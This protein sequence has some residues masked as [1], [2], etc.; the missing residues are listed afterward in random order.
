MVRRKVPSELD[1][2]EIKLS[3]LMN[4]RDSFNEQ[5]NVLRQ[6][7]DQLHEQ[8]RSV[9]AEVRS[10]KGAR[11][12]FVREMRAHKGVRNELQ[13]KAK[14]LVDIRRE[15][16]GKMKENVTGELASLRKD[17]KRIEMEQQTVPMKLD[18][19]N[20]LIENLRATMRHIRE[21]E[22]MKGQQDAV[23]KE[24]R[25]LDSTIDDLFK[26]ADTEHE[27]VVHLSR[28]ANDL[29]DKVTEL[30]KNIAILIVE[31]DKKHEEYLETRE[32]A[33]EIHQ[34]VVEMREKVLT[35]R[36]AQ[37]AEVREVRQYLK[38]HRLEVRRNLYDEK[39]LDEFADKA[40]QALLNKGKVEIRG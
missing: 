9:S 7:R 18:E 24:V 16:R 34:K 22:K 28:K 32:K 8:K 1:K 23:T 15:F 20:E 10:L 39:K 29:H 21:L 37:R 27:Q 11:D 26:D 14:K 30:I 33:D 12:A 40:V 13:D 36:E 2:A 5:A 3:D 31:S 17:F 38:Q 6:E 4:R 35:T 25:D 19:E